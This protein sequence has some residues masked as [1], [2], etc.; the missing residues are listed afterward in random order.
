LEN[1]KTHIAIFIALLFHISGLIGM[2]TTAKPWF[3]SMTPLTLLLMF[4]LYNWTEGIDKKWL[5]FSAIGFI[6][7]IVV[8]IIG[9]KTGLL[10]GSY[11]Y[12]DVMGVKIL[13]VPLLMGI[14]W[15]ITIVC[16]AHLVYYVMSK[17]NWTFGP[18]R[19]AILGALVTTFFDYLIEPAAIDFGYWSWA[20]N[21]IPL[22]NYVCWYVISFILFYCYDRF[23]K[24]EKINYFSVVLIITQMI[25]FLVLRF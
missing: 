8:E 13:G 16:S 7:G 2:F 3:V 20:N 18:F 22:Y 4:G 10:F 1:N 25:F 12:G 17:V 15:L 9:V 19:F 5:I 23:F 6:T 21:I 24:P 11:A 14:Q